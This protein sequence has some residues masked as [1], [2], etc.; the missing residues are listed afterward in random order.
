MK[1]K[2]QIEEITAWATLIVVGL[3][4][5]YP[6]FYADVLPA[7]ASGPIVQSRADFASFMSGI[8]NSISDTVRGVPPVDSVWVGNF[9]AIVNQYRANATTSSTC[10]GP[11]CIGSSST[12]TALS[13]CPSLSAFAQFRFDDMTTGKNY[14]ISHYNYQSDF[15]SYYPNATGQ[16]EEEYFFPTGYSASSFISH[17]QTD[18]PVHWQG[19]MNPTYEYYGYFLGKGPILGYYGVTGTCHAPTEVDGEGTNMTQLG[20]GCSIV[21]TNGTWY[22]IEMSSTCP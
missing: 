16:F 21:T 14:E 1:Y 15:Q 17:I 9:F 4:I 22:V 19:L 11:V 12:G 8:T 10:S 5:I 13:P 6:A 7:S 18:A 3:Y 20:S 2:K